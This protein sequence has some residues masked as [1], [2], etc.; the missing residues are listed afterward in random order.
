[1]PVASLSPLGLGSP[2]AESLSS[3]A[4]RVAAHEGVLPGQLVFRVLV[5]L[6][7][8]QPDMIGRWAPHPR[9]V[10]IG[11]NNNG[12]S[13]ARVWLRLL[14][15][16]TGRADLEALT[17]GT[18]DHNFPTRHFQRSELAVCPLCLSEDKK[19][20]HRLAWLLQAVKVCRRHRT[21][22]VTSCPKC[23]RSMPVIHDRS[24]ILSCPWCA[25]DLRQMN[26]QIDSSGLSE[27]DLWAAEEVGRVIAASSDW[28]HQVEWNPADTL[29]KL[30]DDARLNGI[31]SFARF[32]GTSKSTASY[33][34]TARVRPTL[35]LALYTFHRFGVSLAGH[36]IQKTQ[37]T[38]PMIACTSQPEFRLKPTMRTT[39]RDWPRIRRLLVQE[40]RCALSQA[41]SMAS[42]SKAI[43]IAH[44]TL[45]QRMP[46]LCRLI[47]DRYANYRQS[48]RL[49]ENQMLRG[50]FIAA[51]KQLSRAG[52]SPTWQN[53]AATL[54]QPDLFRRRNARLVY[55]ELVVG[56]RNTAW[57]T[58][59]G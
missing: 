26:R 59:M 55:N 50:Q 37:D 5:W 15:R 10:R 20:Y 8:G 34:F 40:S 54:H 21:A 47:S 11:K 1:M 9:R 48:L 46:D 27:Y 51:L 3:Y 6:D 38:T 7:Q 23:N 39:A 42:V 24:M 44:R 29:K 32:I 14:Q 49:R 18:W 13:H 19:P 25:S 30:C 17:T 52:Q 22:L 2:D 53:I 35:P 41:R 4:Q 31:S 58:R 28:T 36:L 45:Q 33:W 43:G 12:F 57:L 16:L 56:R